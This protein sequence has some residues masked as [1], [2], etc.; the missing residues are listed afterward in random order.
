M[1]AGVDVLNRAAMVDFQ[2]LRNL[3]HAGLHALH[4]IAPLRRQA[5][6]LGLGR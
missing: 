6:A 3:R 2:A 4:G 1:I 5:M